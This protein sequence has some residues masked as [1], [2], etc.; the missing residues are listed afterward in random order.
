MSSRVFH[1]S[2]NHFVVQVNNIAISVAQPFVYSSLPLTSG[3]GR[4]LMPFEDLAYRHTIPISGYPVEWL[5]LLNLYNP[6]V[7]LFPLQYFHVVPDSIPQGQLPSP[8]DRVFGYIERT[9]FTGSGL[10]VVIITNKDLSNTSNSSLVGTVTSEISERL[11]ISDPVTPADIVAPFQPATNPA[12]PVLT[13]I[14]Q[15]VVAPAL[16][17]R[18][19]FGRSFDHIFGLGRCVAS[20][21][22]PGGGKSEWI[23]THYYCSQFGERI[24]TAANMPKIDFFLL[25]SW[26][27]V[28]N[29]NNPLTLFPRF[30]GLIDAAGDFH[31]N[32]CSV[33]SVSGSL[34]F[35]KFT[36][37]Y[38]GSLNTDKIIQC[39]NRLSSSSIDP[40]IQCFNAFDK[41]PIRTVMF[42]QMLNDIIGQRL[43]PSQL[44]SSDFG[45]IYDG[46]SGFY[47]TPKVIALYA[48]Q[49][50][51]NPSAFPVDTWIETFLKWPLSIYPAS[52]RLQG[53]LANTINLGKVE[54]LLWISAQAR[55][56]H[57]SLCNDALWCV[58]YAKPKTPRGANPLACKACLP[59]IR[60]AC[61]AYSRIASRT[62]SFNSSRG[63]N[64][65]EI[66][67]SGKNNTTPNQKFAVCEGTSSQ[68]YVYDN[69]TPVD[70]PS[71]FS[72][73][74]ASSHQGQ[75]LTVSQFISTY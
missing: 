24:Q 43:V 48:E 49:C 63:S 33:R 57:S 23:E 59:S 1:Y 32:F 4:N 58:K 37:P 42:L 65:F 73:Y 67:T 75:T 66:W 64:H 51:G 12:N 52:G 18:L 3:H 8:T 38:G 39:I 20:F 28:T 14:W 69:F 47:Q 6:D 30:R 27:E 72:P 15:R 7:P 9:Q 25:P 74:P 46:L 61:P 71:S 26:K 54:R 53:V 70:T 2:I 44:S 29:P 35:S 40:L 62:I 16:G 19:P 13:Q 36:N 56:I 17:N 22:S 5:P 45:I 21:Y 55:K 60:N 11:G 34:R 41:G 68:G 50:F 31:Q 10:E